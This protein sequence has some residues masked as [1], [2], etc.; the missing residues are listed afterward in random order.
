MRK[1]GCLRIKLGIPKSIRKSRDTLRLL[2]ILKIVKT[3]KI[4][5]TGGDLDFGCRLLHGTRGWAVAA[6]GV[7]LDFT[8]AFDFALDLL[9][10]VKT[11]KILKI[12]SFGNITKGG[13][14][15]KFGNP[16]NNRRPPAWGCA[17]AP[18]GTLP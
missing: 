2:K 17:A 3:L 15:A 18:P 7:F 9:K 12:P 8:K 13:V 10:I 4:L 6:F 16:Q 5:K 11:L 1:W 14:V